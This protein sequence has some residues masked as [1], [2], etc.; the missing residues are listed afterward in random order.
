MQILL[1]VLSFIMSLRVTPAK[2]SGY[3]EKQCRNDRDNTAFITKEA[4]RV[5]AVQIRVRGYKSLKDFLSDI[6]S[7]SQSAVNAGAQLIV[8]PE[9]V[10]LLTGTLLPMFDRLLFWVME[11]RTPEGLD[12]VVLNRDRVGVLAESFQNY[13]YEAYVC[14][15]STI[16]RLLHVYI[17]AGSCLFYEQ[18][19]LYNRCVLF[20]PDGEPVCAQGKTAPLCFDHALG[21]EPVDSVGVFDT[22]LG[23]ISIL[24]GTDAYYYENVKIAA[25]QGAQLILCPDS[26][27]SVTRDLLRCRAA[28]GNVPIVYSCYSH[29]KKPRLRAGILAPPSMSADGSG[30]LCSA[31][32]PSSCTVTQRINLEKNRDPILRGETNSAFLLEDYLHSYLYC[33]N[34]PLSMPAEAKER[35]DLNDRPGNS[36]FADAT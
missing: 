32:H 28:E 9:Y 4:L 36:L 16:A 31:D 24:L 21:V 14:T 7:L 17:A 26:R 10:G 15:F 27:D 35:N 34:I 13:L 1:A 30:I 23:R 8:F 2:I 29:A 18:G 11:G 25:A 20:G 5:S 33:G 6:L 12:E 19:K 22:P 3:L